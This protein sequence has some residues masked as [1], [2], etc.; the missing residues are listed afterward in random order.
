M[1]FKL[2]KNNK[3]LVKIYNI[4]REKL[5]DSVFKK[6]GLSFFIYMT[7]NEIIHVYTIKKNNDISAIITVIDYKN[8]I[9]MNEKII[10]YFIQHPFKILINFISI[11]GSTSKK[12]LIKI[13]E[14]YLHL[15]HLI[16]I[17]KKFTDISIKR[18]DSI[19]N[20]FYKKI[21]KKHSSKV[22]FLCFD[23]KNKKA[24]SYYKR[25]KFNFFYKIKNFIYLKKRYL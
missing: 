14:D 4:I 9:S 10:R 16:I 6:L 11:L 18:K 3:N 19:L 7:L 22:L 8:Y 2:K 24:Q 5:P 12:S 1:S 23:E 15:L 13:N 25:N 20:N 17:K 21:L